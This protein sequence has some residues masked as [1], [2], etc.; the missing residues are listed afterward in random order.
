MK[1][2][3]QFL[4]RPAQ[5]Q[6]RSNLLI[7]HLAGSHAYGTALPTSDIDFR[8]VFVADPV[9]IR[10]PFFHVEEVKDLTEEDTKLYEL[11][12]FVK[13]A[14]DC[15]PNIVETLWVDEADIV[16]CRPAWNLMKQ[17]APRLLSR[18]IAFTTVGYALSQLKRIK[19]HNKWINNPM[20]KEKPQAVDFVSMVQHFPKENEIP[21]FP[22]DFCLR[23]FHKGW[24]LVPFGRDIFGVYQKI[25][26]ET[27]NVDTG[28]LNENVDEERRSE[29]GTPTFIVKYNRP[30]HEDAR[31]RW[32]QYWTWKK[33]RN[34]VRSELEEKFGY[35][36]KHAMHLVRLMRMGREALLEG[37][38]HVKRSDATELL[39]IR[40]GKWTYEEILQYAEQ[41]E[42]EIKALVNTSDLPE[43]AD[44]KFAAQLVLDVQ[45]LMWDTKSEK[46]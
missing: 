13:L 24:K 6:I 44:V 25:N 33:N 35:D 8:G 38:I 2:K 16:T 14:L 9:C 21:M 3:C 37:V 10:T 34:N 15:N 40:N 29:L 39:S 43:Q 12:T 32:E 42:A 22:R 4:L 19:G 18:K 45:D 11:N 23:N 28:S 5:E 30:E 27:F 7:K 26:S 41:M 20:P 31:T 46:E 1:H 17:A 36:T